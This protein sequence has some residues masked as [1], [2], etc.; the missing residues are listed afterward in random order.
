MCVV[1]TFPVCFPWFFFF[2]DEFK[3]SVL[4]KVLLRITSQC[5]LQILLDL[6][7]FSYIFCLFFTLKDTHKFLE[8]L[9]GPSSGSKLG[10]LFRTAKI[11]GTLITVYTCQPV[12]NIVT[13]F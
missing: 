12:I 2:N 13:H 9:S 7:M 10:D 11:R 1:S 6:P 4:M 5:M 3:E 8:I